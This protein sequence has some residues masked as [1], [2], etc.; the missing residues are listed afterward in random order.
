MTTTESPAAPAPAA[1]AAEVYTM[2]TKGRDKYG[3][4]YADLYGP[5]RDGRAWTVVASV[6][7]MPKVW[8]EQYGTRY[9]VTDHVAIGTAA[10][11]QD[12]TTMFVKRAEAI[13]YADTLVARS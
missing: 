2:W 11:P 7:T 1:A 12:A 3:R 10:K 5:A 4:T 8:V 9:M 13:A 6:I